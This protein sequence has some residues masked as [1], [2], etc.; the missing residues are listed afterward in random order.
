MYEKPFLKTERASLCKKDNKYETGFLFILAELSGFKK[1]FLIY[2]KKEAAF[3]TSF[4]HYT[5]TTTLQ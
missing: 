5:Q 3:A 2:I 1:L 4:D